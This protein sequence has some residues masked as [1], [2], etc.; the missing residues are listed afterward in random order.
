[1][2]AFPLK[3]V[4]LVTVS[5]A[6]LIGLCATV[7]LG[8][9]D[10]GKSGDA[11]VGVVSSYQSPVGNM[12]VGDANIGNSDPQSHVEDGEEPEQQEK[13]PPPPPNAVAGDGSWNGIPMAV[14]TKYNQI[15]TA[16]L[17]GVTIQLEPIYLKLRKVSSKVVGQLALA[18]P[19]V[20]HVVPAT[21]K[22]GWI[23]LGARFYPKGST[24]WFLKH[25]PESNMFEATLFDVLNLAETYP[26][27]ARSWFKSFNFVNQ[28]VWV[29]DRGVEVKGKKMAHVKEKG[30][31]DPSAKDNDNRDTWTIQSV[32]FAS[33]LREH[34]T[35]DDFVVLKMDVEGGEWEL[36]KHLDDTG[37]IELIDELMLEC[38]PREA[39]ASV[40]WMHQSCIDL[41]NHYR[42]R[43]IASHRWF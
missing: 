38:H 9:T 43:G 24:H 30:A 29:H 34:Y 26:N 35:K 17:R 8:E 40:S 16:Q 5:V 37:A 19:Q 28:A 32:D 15:L 7:L 23:D 1:M 25:Y 11:D 22:R 41:T 21:A 3:R 36:L 12:P 4:V 18:W 31:D 39:D 14:N 13:A 42:T 20:K 33:W 6:A 27:A 2:S 10:D